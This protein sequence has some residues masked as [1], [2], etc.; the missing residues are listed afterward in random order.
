MTDKFYTSVRWK[1]LRRRVLA[2][3][4]YIDQMRIREGITEEADTVHHI[5][6]REMYPEYQWETWNLIAISGKTHRQLHTPV[7]EL[8]TA[9]RLLLEETARKQGIPT[10]RMI[11]IV[12]LP[13]SGKSTLGK[14]ILAGGLAYDLDHISG[15]LRLKS[16]HSE[17][18]EASRQMANRMLKPFIATARQFTGRVI[19]IRTAPG[20]EEVA[21]ID[22]DEIWVTRNKGTRRPTDAYIDR[23]EIEE[24]ESRIDEIVL[25]AQVNGIPM[26]EYPPRSESE[27]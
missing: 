16:A 7:G 13:G 4:K 24:M 9:G 12:G 22:P 27:Q 8:S 11:L 23:K 17:R 26:K 15:A 19:V 18:H 14:S 5:F 3:A 10:S 20:L 2:K 25:Y 21:E 1:N 6:P